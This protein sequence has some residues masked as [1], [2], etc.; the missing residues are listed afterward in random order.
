MI[1]FIQQILGSTSYFQSTEGKAVNKTVKV[2]APVEITLD[3]KDRSY[4]IN[5]H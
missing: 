1:A 3:G 4:A 2:L 5:G